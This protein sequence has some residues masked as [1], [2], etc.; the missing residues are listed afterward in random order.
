MNTGLV[1]RVEFDGAYAA[2]NAIACI[3]CSLESFEDGSLYSGIDTASMAQ[4][5]SLRVTTAA[6]IAATTVEVTTYALA[7]IEFSFNLMTGE[8]SASI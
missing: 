5:V 3:G 7:D 8:L 2:V 4:P 6:A 1:S